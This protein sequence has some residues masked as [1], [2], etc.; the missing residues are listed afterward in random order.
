M[1]VQ[2]NGGYARIRTTTAKS[3]LE[4][5]PP[6]GPK[7]APG[8][9]PE[10]P[11]VTLNQFGEGRAIYCAAR[12]FA[13]Y[14]QDGTPVLG[15]LARWIFG[16]VH[17]AERRAILLEN[18]PLNVEVTFNSRGPDRFVHLVN[19]TGDKRAGGQRLQEFSTAQGIRIGVRCGARPKR[20]LLAPEKRPV[21]FE[22]KGGRAWFQ[23][24]PLVLHD[25]YMMES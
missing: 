1:D 10:G 25:V 7:Q 2:L 23:A 9:A 24:Q 12:L 19:Y 21:A 6:T 15:K 16:V 3:L 13:G 18:A 20:G 22:W 17:P 14:Q 4:L 11:G 5:V 8:G